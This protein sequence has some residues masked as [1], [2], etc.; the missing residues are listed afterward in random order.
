M[1]QFAIERYI[2]TENIAAFK[3][4]LQTE[5][6]PVT[7]ATLLQLLVQEKGKL[8]ALIEAGQH[9]PDQYR[10]Q[11]IAD[12][13]DCIAEWKQPFCAPLAIEAP[14]GAQASIKSNSTI[15]TSHRQLSHWGQADQH[16]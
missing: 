7:R 12:V 3:T 11:K 15:L 16:E 13:G 6:D 4:R 14:H 2:E 8:A 5:S 9:N 10:S 1:P